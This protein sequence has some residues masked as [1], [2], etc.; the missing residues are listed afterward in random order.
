MSIDDLCYMS[1]HE[2]LKRFRNLSLSPVELLEAIIEKADLIADTVN[3]FADCYFEEARERAKKS[4]ALYANRTVNIGPLEGVPVA[5]KDLCEI[6]GKRTTAG[7]LINDQNISKQTSPHVQRLID[8]G[9]N[10]RDWQSDV[11]GF[12]TD[13]RDWMEI[14]GP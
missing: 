2:A 10:V 13:L 8:A 3:P 14:D 7:S 6:A 4:E 1:A 11:R 9:A 5:V 12:R